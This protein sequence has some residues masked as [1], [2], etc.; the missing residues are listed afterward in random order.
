M[1]KLYYEESGIKIYHGD[2]VGVLPKLKEIDL[3]IT[4]PPYDD[5]R[6]YGGYIFNYKKVIPLLYESMANGAVCIWIVGD[7][8]I[9]GSESGSSFRQ[10]L[11]FMETGFNL[12][13]TMI[14]EKPNFSNPSVNRYHQIF[15]YMFIFSKSSPKCF[16]PI[17]DVPVKYE[18]NFG[19]ST[20]RIKS[21][22][23]VEIA[24]PLYSK[25]AMRGNI[26]KA[27]TTGQLQPCAPIEHPATFPEPLISDHVISWSNGGDLILDPFMGSGTTLRV[28]KDLGRRAIGIEIE[29]KYCEIAAKR[30]AQNSFGLIG[31]E[32]SRR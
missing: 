2:C 1:D 18:K 28:A 31:Q 15:E 6:D 23:M 26:W 25:R 7:Q 3:A 12:H 4:S 5:L 32:K 8:T 21:G 9:N 17:K 22:E 20:R 29:E 30:L 16:N 19:K 14:W 27:K 24:S 11:Y 10:A 13:D